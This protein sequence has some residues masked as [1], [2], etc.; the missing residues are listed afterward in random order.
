MERLLHAAAFRGGP[1]QMMES[2]APEIVLSGP[3]GTGKSRA[4]L[5]KLHLAMLKYPGA[6]A[7]IVRK[8]ARSLGSTT[9]STFR[10]KVAQEAIQSRTVAFYSGSPQKAAGYTYD[11][12]SVIVVGGL[13]DP[14]KIMSSEYDLVFVDECTEA[15]ESDWQALGTRLRNGRLPYQQILGACNPSAPTHWIRTRAHRNLELITSSHRD[16]PAYFTADGQPTDAGAAYLTQLDSLTGVQRLRLLDGQWAAAEGVIWTGFDPAKH[17]VER[18]EVP[19]EW[20]LTVSVDFG[21]VHPFAAQFWRTD[22][23]G[24]MY[25]QYEIMY[26]QRLV[27]D[28]AKTMLAV[29][30][31]IGV[32]P[33]SVVRDHQA[34]DGATLERH[35]GLSTKKARKAVSEG[36][37]AVAARFKEAGDGKPRL[38]LME[39]ALWEVDETLLDGGAPTCLAEEIPGYVWAD[40]RIKEEPVKEQDDACDTMRYAVQQVDNGP[41]TRLRWM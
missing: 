26:T 17:I 34:E 16:N 37:Q 14:T 23:D 24:R 32:Q 28:H 5:T 38:F 9:L 7:L 12:G 20:P 36:I 39:D 8:T 22:P 31:K 15:T 30:D 19:R 1:A 3:A 41:R 13:D 4:V 33:R 40:H 27:E 11:N 29:L 35:L 18:F 25:L 10:E 21:F 6:K 2:R